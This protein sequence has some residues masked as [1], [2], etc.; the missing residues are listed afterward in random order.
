MSYT[1]NMSA[2]YRDVALQ[3]REEVSEG[4][5][6]FFKLFGATGFSVLAA[7]ACGGGSTGSS[8]SGGGS[9]AP[10][11]TPGGDLVLNDY[12]SILSPVAEGWY[13]LS[14]L[15]PERV[16]MNYGTVGSMPTSVLQELAAWHKDIAYSPAGPNSWQVSN[17]VIRADCSKDMYGCL[18]QEMICSFNTT[19]GMIKTLT[20]IKWKKNDIILMTN[21]EHGGGLG[22]AHMVANRYGVKL[23]EVA[24][25]TGVSKGAG[26][27]GYAEDGTLV[28]RFQAAFDWAKQ[29]GYNPRAIMISSPPYTL[30]WRLEEKALCQWAWEHK[31]ISFVDGAHI[32]GSAPID[33][34]A[35]G[36]DFFASTA[37]KWQCGPGQ[38]GY[39]Y[40]RM[41]K[42]GD[43]P[44]TTYQGR[45]ITVNDWA[46][47]NAIE[48]FY[49]NSAAYSHFPGKAGYNGVFSLEKGHDIG[50]TV[51]SMGNANY[52]TLKIMYEINKVWQSIGRVNIAKYNQSLAQY[53]RQQVAQSE[54]MGLY[55][56]GVDFQTPVG[57]V[58]TGRTDE[59]N[60]PL[61]LQT[62]LTGIN[63]F[64]P[65]KDFND[66]LTAEQAS[67]QSSACS[68]VLKRLETEYGLIARNMQTKHQLR[69]NPEKSAMATQTSGQALPAEQVTASRPLRIST[70]LYTTVA[71]VDRLIEALNNIL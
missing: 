1:H 53:L 61:Y 60:F 46:N 3:A 28:K 10:T 19:D 4:R 26:T 15:R 35:M 13:Y 68:A 45:N 37:A 52:P 8:V 70:H 32:A 47:P 65:N 67:A 27:G 11:P 33:L 31:M 36:C 24:V 43:T 51:A 66:V 5:K 57:V 63:P 30:G 7:A 12:D 48:P 58:P 44:T 56:L 54:K 9:V 50:A 41:G 62:G 18:P 21:N 14:S 23:R 16:H 64:G 29:A 22:P 25:P 6:E 20:G 59:T 40:V 39:A 38:N 71:N 69:S 34:H 17:R 2:E 55:S 49:V 42:K